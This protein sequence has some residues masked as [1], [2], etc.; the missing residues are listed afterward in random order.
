[1]TM[2]MMPREAGRP[3]RRVMPTGYLVRTGCVTQQ[4]LPFQAVFFQKILDDV[5][6]FATYAWRNQQSGRPTDWSGGVHEGGSSWVGSKGL[7]LG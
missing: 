5:M 7:G 3:G 2:S 1:M 6:G 4:D